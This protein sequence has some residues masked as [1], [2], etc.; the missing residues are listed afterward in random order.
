VFAAPELVFAVMSKNPD[1]DTSLT[2]MMRVQQDPADPSAWYEFV[3]KYQPM[4]RVWCLKWGSQASDADDL[5]QQVLLKLTSAMKTY[6]IESCSSFRGWLKTVTHN[7]WIDFIRRPSTAQAPDWIAS[8]ADSHDA[9]EDLDR[10]MEQAYEREL[11]ELAMKRVEPRVK[12]ST[13]EAFRLTSLENLSGAEA[14]GRLGIPASNVFV[15]KH[16][17]LRLLEEEVRMLGG[18]PD[19]SLP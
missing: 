17:V 19:S 9:L 7:A 16:R 5:A 8:L 1:D 2:L 12:P 14:A 6:R 3:Q 15:A 18:G 10:Q 11:L 4:I 13:W